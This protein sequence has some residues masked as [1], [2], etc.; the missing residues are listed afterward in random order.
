[1]RRIAMV[2]SVIAGVLLVLGIVEA[3]TNYQWTQGDQ[4]PL[5]G[6][7]RILLNDGTTV[8]IA[9]GFLVIGSAIMWV[10]A[11]RK[12]HGDQRRS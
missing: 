3:V 6:D 1:M 7:P 10:I 11:L 12:G 2:T 4:D 9:A 5:F 8:L